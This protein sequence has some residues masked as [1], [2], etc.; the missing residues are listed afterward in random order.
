MAFSAVIVSSISIKFFIKWQLIIVLNSKPVSLHLRLS[1][2]KR[3]NIVYAL[4]LQ[5]HSDFLITLYVRNII[6]PQLKVH[7]RGALETALRNRLKTCA[8]CDSMALKCFFFPKNYKKLPNSRGLCLQTLKAS[9]RWGPRP[10]TPVCDTF[11]LHWLSQN[12]SKVT[13]L[14]FSAI[15]V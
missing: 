14:H 2:F 4:G 13:Y 12:V 3:Q 7:G 10:Q 15:L 1:I 11:E 5:V 6:Q 9:G 8:E